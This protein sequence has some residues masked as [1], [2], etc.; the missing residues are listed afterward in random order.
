[1]RCS[2]SVAIGEAS[3]KRRDRKSD[4]ARG[5]SLRQGSP[6]KEEGCD[7]KPFEATQRVRHPPG[8]GGARR[9]EASL[10]WTTATAFVKLDSGR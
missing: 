10:A 6:G 2:A 9:P 3:A 5:P 7:L 1:M 8:K 4:A